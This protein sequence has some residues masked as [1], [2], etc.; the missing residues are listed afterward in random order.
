MAIKLGSTDINTLKLGSTNIEKAYL[1]STEIFGSAF[2]PIDL[3]PLFW[4]DAS[5]G[6]TE[7]GGA[8]S[9]WADQSGNGNDFS[10]S[11][12]SL[13]PTY[14]AT[15]LNSLP[16]IIFNNKELVS[17]VLSSSISNVTVYCVWKMDTVYNGATILG[18]TSGANNK[19]FFLSL[20]TIHERVKGMSL[21]PDTL[22]YYSNFNSSNEFFKRNIGNGI[23]CMLATAIDA[24]VMTHMSRFMENYTECIP[25]QISA[26]ASLFANNVTALICAE[27]QS[28]NRMSVAQTY[29]LY[30]NVSECDDNVQCH[31]THT[32]SDCEVRG[33]SQRDTFPM[34]RSAMIDTGANR[35]FLYCNIEQWM[36]NAY[37][38][39]ATA[40]TQ[41]YRRLS[42]GPGANE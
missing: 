3:S 26:E 37:P 8:V 32:S 28:G 15:G 12:G 13:Q 38:C 25:A 23:S 6:V 39:C 24:S 40:N 36:R 30:T 5:A 1:G 4:M 11:S 27:L 10:Q 33:A 2:S 34:I 22:G 41:R 42:R 31:F 18:Q 19:R 14:D 20:S 17:G 21:P 7:S 9:A 16:T 29:A 35:T